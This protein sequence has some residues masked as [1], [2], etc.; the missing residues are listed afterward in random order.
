MP[1]RRGMCKYSYCRVRGSYRP[2]VQLTYQQTVVAVAS[3]KR[4]IRG[5]SFR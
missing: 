1:F 2:N 4:A 3:V 5:N